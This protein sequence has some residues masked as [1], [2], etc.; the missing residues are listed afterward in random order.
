MEA[1]EEAE[2]E[3]QAVAMSRLYSVTLQSQTLPVAFNVVTIPATDGEASAHPLKAEASL[4]SLGLRI[5]EPFSLESPADASTRLA[6][7]VAFTLGKGRKRNALEIERIYE[8]RATEFHE[9]VSWVARQNF[10]P[11]ESSPLRGTNLDS[12]MKQGSLMGFASFSEGYGLVHHDPVIC[13]FALP[14][15]VIIG[16][17][18]GAGE[19][20][21]ERVKSLLGA[22]KKGRK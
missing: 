3:A 10:I 22:T 12:L 21:Q 2:P 19:G 8:T 13:I 17:A 9:F 4:E 5:Y 1:E 14:M 7:L 11:V 20:I 6:N 16:A 15:T 18:V